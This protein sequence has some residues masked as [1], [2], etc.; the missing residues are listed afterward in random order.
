MNF[1]PEQ[2]QAVLGILGR[3]LALAA[4]LGGLFVAFEPPPHVVYAATGLGATTVL[5]VT[6]TDVLGKWRE[7]GG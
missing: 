3:R 2:I 1:T 6:A 7:R 5:A 4:V